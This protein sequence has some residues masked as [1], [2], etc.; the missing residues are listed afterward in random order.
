MAQAD[1]Q[2]A[3]ELLIDS[4]TGVDVRLRVAGPGARAYAF[5]IDWHIRLVLA[6]AWYALAA[7]LY[8]GRLSLV[9]PLEPSARWFA[10]VVAPA[11][12]IFF[13]YHYVLEVAMRGRTPGKRMAGVLIVTR[14]GSTPSV[15]ALLARNVFRLIDSFPVIYSVGLLTVMLTRL[16]VRVGDLAA[17]TL[18]V[19][20][21]VQTLPI[22]LHTGA[23]ADA[24]EAEAVAELLQRWPALQPEVRARLARSVLRRHR[25]ADA[26]LPASEGDLR[27]ELARL[28][29]AAS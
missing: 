8:N 16:H 21:R 10:S 26:E 25:G 29:G 15:G 20:A 13:L 9:A 7:M 27:S 3:S 17:G 18:L 28:L 24:A 5:V 2:A 23:I 19:Y 4:A 6:L 1:V 22:T 11:A 12:A 14:S